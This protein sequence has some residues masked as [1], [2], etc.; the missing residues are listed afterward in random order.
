MIGFEPK[1][2]TQD[3]DTYILVWQQCRTIGPM[4]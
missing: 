3:E 4:K 2:E 1:F